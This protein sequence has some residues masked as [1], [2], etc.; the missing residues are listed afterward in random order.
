MIIEVWLGS[1]IE[2]SLIFQCGIT[3][4]KAKEVFLNC[5][6]VSDTPSE[7]QQPEEQAKTDVCILISNEDSQAKEVEL[8]E[9]MNLVSPKTLFT[10]TCIHFLGYAL[11]PERKEESL[12]TFF[13]RVEK[14]IPR[15]TQDRKLMYDG[16]RINGPCTT[17]SICRGPPIELGY[18]TAEMN[19]L[20]RLFEKR[21]TCLTQ[22]VLDMDRGCNLSDVAYYR[23]NVINR[24]GKVVGSIMSDVEMFTI[25]SWIHN[26]AFNF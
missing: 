4:E 22:N 9:A 13:S 20:W 10:W 12:A 5:S 19:A 17:S 3:I 6:V 26:T 11:R 15:L 8:L 23:R 7:I 16:Y 2:L 18:D 21:R 24:Q 25:Y 1:F 14:V